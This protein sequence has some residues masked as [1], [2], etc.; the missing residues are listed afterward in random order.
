M[1]P[2]VMSP[3]PVRM[4]H[5]CAFSR[6]SFGIAGAG[7]GPGK[8]LP[9]E[10]RRQRASRNR[11]RGRSNRQR[12]ARPRSALSRV[13]RL[14][15]CVLQQ[16]S[17]GRGRACRGGRQRRASPPTGRHARPLGAYRR[18]IGGAVCRLLLGGSPIGGRVALVLQ[19]H[20]DRLQADRRSAA[21]A[22]H[23]VASQ[24]HRCFCAWAP[25]RVRDGAGRHGLFRL[26]AR[27]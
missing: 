10:R 5:E 26:V 19:R 8:F 2:C 13:R 16:A 17:V 11:L 7:I 27:R 15:R 22:C 21:R 12:R 9:Q 6:T 25:R 20:H 18:S 14:D 3:I 23:R 4:R 1:R 24:H